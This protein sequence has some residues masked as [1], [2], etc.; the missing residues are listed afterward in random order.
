MSPRSRT[1]PNTH[2]GEV[3]WYTDMHFGTFLQLYQGMLGLKDPKHK[4]D[5]FLNPRK[6]SAADLREYFEEKEINGG[7]LG[8]TLFFDSYGMSP[9]CFIETSFRYGHEMT[10]QELLN[11]IEDFKDYVR[12]L[13]LAKDGEGAL[14]IDPNEPGYHEE[15]N[16]RWLKRVTEMNLILGAMQAAAREQLRSEGIEV[17]S[18]DDVEEDDIPF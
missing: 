12:S 6:H 18:S 15:R 3:H 9:L 14:I 11:L 10:D 8:L 17:I 1:P 5:K 4:D 13:P 7:L 2:L 16:Q